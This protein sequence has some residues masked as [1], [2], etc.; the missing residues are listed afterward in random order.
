MDNMGWFY[1]LGVT[2]FLVFLI[3]IALSRFRR[4]KLGPDDEPAEHSG[5]SWFAMLFAAGIGTILM[6][7]GV[8]EPVSHFGDPP[9]QGGEP[10]SVQAA[11]GARACTLYHFT[12]HSWAIVAV[13]GLAVGSFL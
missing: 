3:Y 9:R 6:F 2:T 11:E 8:A 5:K 4:I 13:P 1:V 10:G 7:W 12:Y